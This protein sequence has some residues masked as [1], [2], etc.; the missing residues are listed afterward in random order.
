VCPFVMALGHGRKIVSQH[1]DA[2]HL[3]SPMS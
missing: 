3:V 1:T 2:A